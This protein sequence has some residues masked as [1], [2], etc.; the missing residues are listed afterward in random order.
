MMKIKEITESA[1]ICALMCILSQ[2]AVPLPFTAIVLSL[3]LTGIYF[4]GGLLPPRN[5]FFSILAYVFLG[6]AGVPVFAKFGSGIGTL[7]GPTGGFLAAY[8]LG[9]FIIALILKKIGKGYLKYTAA[10]IAGTLICHT[11]GILWFTIYSKTGL[12]ASAMAVSIPFIPFDLI[13][14]LIASAICDILDRRL[15]KNNII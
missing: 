15:K 2:I 3:G 7:T 14:I 10:M 4:A 8:P 9:A 1:L 11:G 5:A 6:I 13:K 12:W